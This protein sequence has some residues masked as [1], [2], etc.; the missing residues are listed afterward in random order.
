MSPCFFKLEIQERK[1]RRKLLKGGGAGVVCARRH[2]FG[3]ILFLECGILGIFILMVGVEKLGENELGVVGR[4][5]FAPCSQMPRLRSS[6]VV[7][8]VKPFMFI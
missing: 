3:G 7:F 1:Q 6:Y 2:L 8:F 4:R 5:R